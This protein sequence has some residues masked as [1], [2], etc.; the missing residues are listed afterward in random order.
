MEIRVISVHSRHIILFLL[1]N[2]VK[3]RLSLDDNKH[4]NLQ[5]GALKS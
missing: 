1:G 4:L 2:L 5:A 3:V